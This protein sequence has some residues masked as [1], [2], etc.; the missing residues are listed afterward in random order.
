MLFSLLYQG[1][2]IYTQ[3]ILDHHKI[4]HKMIQIIYAFD[5]IKYVQTKPN[6]VQNIISIHGPIQN[7]SNNSNQT[8]IDKVL[9]LGHI[10][11]TNQPNTYKFSVI[12]FNSQ[13]LLCSKSLHANQVRIDQVALYGY[14]SIFSS[15]SKF[16]SANNI[17]Y[18]KRY[19]ITVSETD[20]ITSIVQDLKKII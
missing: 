19:Y 5:N 7:N 11:N 20:A 10:N 12:C 4:P 16:R 13:L 3:H 17:Q 1:H 15:V 2:M 18:I 8:H 6:K 14:I 9:I